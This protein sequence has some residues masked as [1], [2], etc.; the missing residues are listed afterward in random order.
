MLT[1]ISGSC[2]LLL[3]V[4]YCRY[5]VHVHWIWFDKYSHINLKYWKVGRIPDSLW[6]GSWTYN[7]DGKYYPPS[8]PLTC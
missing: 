7:P 6:R 5:Y 1:G 4:H 2:W 3:A 8:Q